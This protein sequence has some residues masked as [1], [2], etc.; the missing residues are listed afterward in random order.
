M[1]ISDWSSDVCSSDLA[2]LAPATLA[3]LDAALPATWSHGNP[4]DIIGDAP[5]ERYADAVHAVLEDPGVDAVLVMHAP[6]AI[7]P[8]LQPAQAVIAA[9]HGSRK[10]VDGKSRGEGKG[11]AVRVDLRWQR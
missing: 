5:S 8:S 11:V 3:R 6:T 2:D 10:N 7:V 1:R 4:V 9:A